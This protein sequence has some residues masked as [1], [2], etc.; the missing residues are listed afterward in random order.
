MFLSC[1]CN[2]SR[3]PFIFTNFNSHTDHCQEA[4]TSGELMVVF[5]APPSRL[6]KDEFVHDCI[7]VEGNTWCFLTMVIK[8]E[9]STTTKDIFVVSLLNIYCYIFVTCLS[10]QEKV[11]SPSKEKV[12]L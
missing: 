2:F 3:E 12:C 5:S 11:N 6:V 4:T 9:Q 1:L 10:F 7:Q 8:R